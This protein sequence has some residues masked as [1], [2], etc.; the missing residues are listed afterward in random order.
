MISIFI[1]L[2]QNIVHSI[3]QHA[4]PIYDDAVAQLLKSQVEWS[5]G[6]TWAKFRD[7]SIYKGLIDKVIAVLGIEQNDYKLI[8][9]GL[10]IYAKY[11][12]AKTKDDSIVDKI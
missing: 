12:I 1:P 4:Y 10:W 3:I 9:K 11:L 7:Y 6:I 2:P 5:K 8:D